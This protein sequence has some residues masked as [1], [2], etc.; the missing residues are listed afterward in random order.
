[1]DWYKISKKKPIASETGN[2][3][4]KRSD[5]MLLRTADGKNYLGRM[6]EDFVDGEHYQNFYD[7]RDYELDNVVYWYPI[8]EPYEE[9]LKTSKDWLVEFE[10]FNKIE[11]I[12][13]DGWDRTNF[14][15]SFNEEL[16]TSNEFTKRL[17]LCTVKNNT[18]T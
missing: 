17:L 5:E 15:F 18:A 4:G 3:N 7:N 11:I 1:M 12:D 10:K 2:W 14:T 9:P 6:Y 13:Y 16:I 8:A